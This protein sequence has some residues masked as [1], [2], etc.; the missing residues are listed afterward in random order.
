MDPSVIVQSQHRIPDIATAVRQ[1]LHGSAGKSRNTNTH[2]TAS[3]AP[4]GAST[5][6]ELTTT[7]IATGTG[8]GAGAGAGAAAGNVAPAGGNSLESALVA[9][10]N[11]GLTPV[12][13]ALLEAW[14]GELD[15]TA[16]APLGR[17]LHAAVVAGHAPVCELLLQTGASVDGGEGI[18]ASDTKAVAVRF[19]QA[20]PLMVAATEGHEDVCRILL[21]AKACVNAVANTTTAAGPESAIY[22]AAANGHAHIVTLLLDHGARQGIVGRPDGRTALAEAAAG[23]HHDVVKVLIAAG[24]RVDERDVTGGT[25]LMDA[26]AAGSSRCMRLLIA[27]GASVHDVNDKG[28]GPLTCACAAG[29]VAAVAECLRLDANPNCLDDDGM[30]PLLAAVCSQVEALGGNKPRAEVNDTLFGSGHGAL[31]RTQ[32]FAMGVRAQCEAAVATI[33]SSLLKAGAKHAVADRHGTTP[34]M[35]AVARGWTSAT[36]VLVDAGADLHDRDEVSETPCRLTL[37]VRL[38]ICFLLFLPCSASRPLHS[39]VGHVSAGHCCSHW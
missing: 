14:E 6:A 19:A 7:T 2:T 31:Q 22:C 3:G 23:G 27:A 30:T 15:A 29:D 25:P 4:S 38:R 16:K 24:A 5:A 17:A 35:H 1:W 21:A 9:A 26:A 32:Y 28:F 12:V 36:K 37:C 10:A 20:T 11:L 18:A 33:V 13:Q 8:A 34:L 39:G